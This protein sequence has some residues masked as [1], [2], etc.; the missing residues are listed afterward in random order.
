MPGAPVVFE[1]HGRV[2][3][4]NHREALESNEPK[5][6][7][8]TAV[9]RAAVTP[10]SCALVLSAGNTKQNLIESMTR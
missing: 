2:S 1:F 4:S 5:I 7:L 10:G 8:A 3:V 9:A 6:I